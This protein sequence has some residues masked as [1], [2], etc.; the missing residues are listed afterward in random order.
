MTG[1]ELT[2]RSR[3]RGEAPGAAPAWSAEF[4]REAPLA[5][6]VGTG[7][8]V[9]MEAHAGRHPEMNFVGIERA[10]EFYEKV[11]KRIERAG[12]SNVRCVRGDAEEILPAWFEAGSLDEFICLF[13]DPW[14]KRRHRERRV[15]R[16]E[17][18]DLIE[19]RLKPE[20]GL[21]FR[22]DVGWYFNL[23]VNLIRRRP[24]WRF[25]SIGPV[26][27]PGIAGAG[28]VT[29]FERKGREAGSELR[30][31]AD[32]IALYYSAGCSSRPRALTRDIR[33]ER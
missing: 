27:E 31:E 5:L 12:L 11:R 14:P 25:E 32:E 2:F 17:V 20:G 28:V 33:R 10:G 15:F 26:L 19:S 7:N 29:N 13:S 3:E 21:W 18:L 4:G 22:S 24:Q 30:R 1:I 16:P 8:G 9:F 23:T 6:E